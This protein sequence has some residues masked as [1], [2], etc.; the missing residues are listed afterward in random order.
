MFRPENKLQNDQDCGT[1]ENPAKDEARE[2][3]LH[4]NGIN[5]LGDLG[6]HDTVEL[7]V[8]ALSDHNQ[9]GSDPPME[10][11]AQVATGFV[12]PSAPATT[13]PAPYWPCKTSQPQQTCQPQPSFG[14]TIQFSIVRAVGGGPNWVLT[15]FKG[16]GGGVTGTNSIAGN[17]ASLLNF[18]RSDQHT[19]WLAFAPL[20]VAQP[21]TELIDEIRQIDKAL[22]SIAKSES[23]FRSPA[24][25]RTLD[26]ERQSLQER[27]QALQSELKRGQPEASASQATAATQAIINTMIL[28][29]L[30]SFQTPP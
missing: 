2:E 6:I 22:Q 5:L 23:L 19:L 10:T 12:Q 26:T 11:P 15:R 1:A 24:E 20:P 8:N 3:G 18:G 9:M 27:K 13:T 28:Q 25:R 16:P 14:A 29:N 17:S 7:G 4:I 21:A 30:Q